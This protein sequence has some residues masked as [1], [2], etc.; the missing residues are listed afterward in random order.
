MQK[1]IFKTETGVSIITPKFS[2]ER[3]M[4]FVPKGA[5]YKI[6]NSED[7]PKDRTF[8]DAWNFDL[9][10]DIPKSKEIWK[11]KLRVDRKPL[12]EALDVEAIRANENGES[13]VDIVKEKNK[14]RNIT[15]LVDKCKTITAIK[16][17]TI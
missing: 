14:L 5:E 3:S 2:V 15:D 13:I 16:K 10:E 12:L 7:L 6:I 11:D 9:K 4:R 17:V 1:I 8:R